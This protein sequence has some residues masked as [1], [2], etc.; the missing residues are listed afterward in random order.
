MSK[1]VGFSLVIFNIV[2]NKF[3]DEKLY[4]QLPKYLYTSYTSL[5]VYTHMTRKKLTLTI[6]EEV[7]EKYKKFCE[8]NDTI[9]SR[10]LERFMKKDMKK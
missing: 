9:I 5:Y 10:R 3:I 6:D 2:N 1:K 4:T 7:L 8:D